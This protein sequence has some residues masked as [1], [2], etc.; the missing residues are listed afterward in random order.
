MSGKKRPDTINAPQRLL[1][2]A[3]RLYEGEMYTVVRIE[4]EFRVRS[5]A[6]RVDMMRIAFYLPCEQGFRGREKTLRIAPRHQKR[7]EDQ[8]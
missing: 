8:S 6:A 7:A 4:K 5:S 2:I 1:T 3:R